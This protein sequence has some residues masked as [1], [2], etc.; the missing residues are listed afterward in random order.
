[1]SMVEITISGKR[2]LVPAEH[3]AKILRKEALVSEALALQNA[4]GPVEELK[5]IAG[6]IIRLNRQIPPCVQFI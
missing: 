2:A 6:K 3:K 5:K 4:G 1:M